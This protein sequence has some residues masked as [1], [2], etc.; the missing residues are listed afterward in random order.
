MTVSIPARRRVC[1]AGAL[2]QLVI[3]LFSPAEAWAQPPELERVRLQLKWRHQFQFAGY[4]A[5]L[6]KGFYREAGLEVELRE[7]QADVSPVDSVLKGQSEF[8]VYGTEL[9]RYRAS[10][11]PLVAVAAVFQHSPAVI[12]CRRDHGISRVSDLVGKRICMEP[13]AADL[14]AYLK[15]KGV[16]ANRFT[17][18][19]RSSTGNFTVDSLIEGRVDGMYVY[20]T[21]ELFTLKNAGLDCAVFS[22]R[23][24][25]IDFY[26]DILFTTEQL[27]AKN[28]RMMRAFREATVKGWQYAL[29]HKAEIVRLIFDKYSTR[30]SLEHL[31]FE[32]D[33]MQQLLEPDLVE[34]GYMS[35][36]RWQ[37][38]QDTYW[39]LGL[40][41]G[42][43]DLERFLYTPARQQVVVR[44]WKE[45]ILATLVAGVALLLSWR[46]RRLALNLRQENQQRQDTEAA[47][48]R[49]VEEHKR[50][51][52]AL[53]LQSE[54]MSH[55]NEGV[56]LTRA[57]DLSIVLTNPKLDQMFGYRAGELVGQ[58]ISVLN[59]PGDKPPKEVAEAILQQLR[60]K[61]TWEGEVLNRKK[62]GTP[63]WCHVAISKFNHSV[64][65]EVWIAAHG[66]ISAIKRLETALRQSEQFAFATLDAL[67]TN[68]SVL[69]QKGEILAVNQAWR[70]FSQAA[71]SH[72]L[73]A[74]VG[75][76]YLEICDAAARAGRAEAA[77]FAA[78]IRAVL[79]GERATFSLEYPCHLPTEK[80]WFLGTVTRFAQADPPRLVVA[81]ENLTPLKQAEEALRKRKQQLRHL[82]DHLPSGMIYQ[83]EGDS[84]GQRRF[85]YVS[86]GVK[87]LF[88]VSEAEVLRDASVIYRQILEEERAALT[89]REAEC[90]KALVPLQ[91]ETRIRRPDG[92]VRW[93][94]FTSAPSQMDDGPVRW[95]GLALDITE[96]RRLE[97]QLRQAQKMEGIGHLAGGMAHEFNNI[98]AGMMFTLALAQIATDAAERRQLL[99]DMEASCKRAAELVK[100]LLA[101]SRQS[102]MQ[103]QP[104]DLAATVSGQLKL[105]KQ[106]LGERI[107]V[108]FINVDGLP[109]VK[110]DRALLEQVLLNLCLNARDAMKNGGALRLEVTEKEV[111]KQQ[112]K[113]HVEAR[114]GRYVCL[115]VSDTGSGMDRRTLKRLFEPFFTTKEV[116]QGTGLG[117][118]TVRGIVQQHEGWV[119]VASRLGQGSTFRVYLPAVAPTTPEPPVPGEK[120][121]VAGSGTILLVEDEPAIRQ[122]CRMLLLQNGYKVLE[123][124]DGTEALAVWAVHR[125]EIDLL[126]TDMVMPG[127]LS[128]LQLA[129]RA[130]AEKPDLKVIITSGYNTDTVGLDTAAQ[131]SVVYLPKPCPPKTL[132]AAIQNSLLKTNH[133]AQ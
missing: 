10:G 15:L 112:A 67:T 88:G 6:E 117:L 64:F 122:L 56:N 51:E 55:M 3:L 12:A 108:E 85:T 125:S 87:H 79:A 100:Q 63:L 110:A 86:A 38:I 75:S 101:F 29:A 105:L 124:T 121:A 13:D 49:K 65:G 95:N 126:H 77:A 7:A 52:E 42:E 16:E 80:R 24:A 19:L 23:E 30:H 94:Y 71:P 43:V 35:R 54:M 25:G 60:Q 1:L 45:T 59:A 70:L 98:L 81:H 14:L 133:A 4:Y 84:N 103:R 61:G 91:M 111:G 69:D 99:Q 8:G 5:A 28:P 97:E 102:V 109:W 50:A 131:A 53:R 22:P 119:E 83:I 128:G 93:I 26:A 46:Y 115:S 90:L 32:A 132:L 11:V 114:P 106:F 62:D 120:S 41:N 76:N 118:A 36:P 34:I 116:G 78:G 72:C 47:L 21:D 89:A 9:L 2:L 31:Q 104:I 82:G 92:E 40:L 74:G 127:E 113:A 66:D 39:R 107:V 129:Q 123:A 58:H 48:R 33:Q 130:L 57:Q 27:L 20:T 37:A 73:A 17:N 18:P 96:R 44:Y 68:I